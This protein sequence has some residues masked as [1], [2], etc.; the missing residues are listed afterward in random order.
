MLLNFRA[1][2]YSKLQYLAQRDGKSVAAFVAT[3]CDIYVD[4]TVSTNYTL[5]EEKETDE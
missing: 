3:L 5:K 1:E 2:T 4:E